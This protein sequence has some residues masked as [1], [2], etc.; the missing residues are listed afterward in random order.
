VASVV[1]VHGI[2]QQRSNS[3]RQLGSWSDGLRL[4]MAAAG[5]SGQPLP[6][7]AVAFY[8]YLFVRGSQFLGVADEPLAEDETAFVAAALD[9][10]LAGDAE[11]EFP[12]IEAQGRV[13]GPPA[14]VP[15]PLLRALGRVDHCWGQRAGQSVVRVLRQVYAYLYRPTVGEEIRR[16]VAERVGADTRVLIGHSLGSVVVY[17]LLRRGV[18]EV[19]TVVT[20]GSPLATVRRALHGGGSDLVVADGVR[21]W[22]VFDSWDVVTGGR[23]LGPFAI[24]EPVD[25]GRRDPHALV[26]YL[27]QPRTAQLV[28]AGATG[29]EVR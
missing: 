10:L 13:L 17:D 12:A 9:E 11:E 4:G 28:I 25:N 21:W 15:P 16:I 1:G 3:R 6:P 26:A 23:G 27:R 2:G 18:V 7:M 20:L 5:L 24:D 22:N 29:A 19:D 8:G 14:L